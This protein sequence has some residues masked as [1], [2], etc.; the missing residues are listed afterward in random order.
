VASDSKVAICIPCLPGIT[1]GID[2]PAD[3]LALQENNNLRNK[4]EEQDQNDKQH[5]FSLCLSF[6]K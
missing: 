1:G 6:V 4:V 5:T 3:G 2:Y